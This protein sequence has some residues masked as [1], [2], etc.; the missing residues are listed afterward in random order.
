MVDQVFGEKV[1]RESVEASR[2]EDWVIGITGDFVFIFSIGKL[3]GLDGV[4][5]VSVFIGDTNQLVTS[6]VE[7]SP[8][9]WDVDIRSVNGGILPSYVNWSSESLVG[10]RRS[11]QWN[12][13]NSIAITI[14]ASTQTVRSIS[15]DFS[16]SKDISNSIEEAV[17]NS[18]PNGSIGSNSVDI[19]NW[20]RH[21]VDINTV[22][23][24]SP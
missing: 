13:V 8:I 2:V 12:N 15:Y 4:T 16:V 6:V 23:I 7:I 24:S 17:I 10:R 19:R 21:K 22:I 18:I 5:H 3:L 14:R 20:I 11:L 1:S 9:P